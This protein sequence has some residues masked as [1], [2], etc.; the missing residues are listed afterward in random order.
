MSLG[1]TL[2][3]LWRS[4]SLRFTRHLLG[5][6]GRDQGLAS[7]SLHGRPIHYRP[8]T[9]DSYDLYNILLKGGHKAAYWLPAAVQPRVILDIGGNIGLSAIYFAIRYPQAVIHSFEP[10][11]DNFALLTKNLAPY[12]QARAHGVALGNRDGTEEIALSDH[13]ANYAGASFY[14]LGVNPARKATVQLRRAGEYL[15]QQ[16]IQG[17]DLIKI[18]TEGAE[19]DILTSLDPAML[20]QAQWVFGEL[21]G[22]KDFLVLDLLARHFEVDVKRSLGRRLFSF[23]ACRKDLAPRLSRADIR[24][25]QY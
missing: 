4:R 17:A 6:P 2:K 12:P 1:N 14:G 5:R 18:D 15:A 9:S 21:H 24:R 16:G 20:S 23:H 22:V 3:V 11:P 8:G 19:Y 13:P 7:Y 25:L 10:V